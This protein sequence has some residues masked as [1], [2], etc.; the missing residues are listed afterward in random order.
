MTLDEMVAQRLKAGHEEYGDASFRR[1]PAEL[2]RE[3]REE[4]ADVIGWSTILEKVLM[5]IDGMDD[6]TE[7]DLASLK[8][9]AH[10]SWDIIKDMEDAADV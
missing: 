7:A 5:R 3:I 1:S 2:R 10:I 4:I 6:K 9:L 8:A